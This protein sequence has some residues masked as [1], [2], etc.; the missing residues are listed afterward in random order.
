MSPMSPIPPAPRASVIIPHY[1][2]PAALRRCLDSVLAQRLDRGDFEII[3]VDNN[4]AEFPAGVAAAYPQVRFLREPR[5]GPGLARNAGVA[6]ATAP[7]LAFI[8]A[9]CRAEA[10]W[11][12]A[13]VDAIEPDP[14]RRIAG[15]DV[16]IDFVD[17][18]ALTALE[19][20]EAVFAYRQRFYIE[21]KHFSGTGNLAMGP[22][23]HAAVGPFAGI[24]IAEDRDWGT[25]AT[26]AGYTIRYVEAMRIYHP[27]RT[28]YAELQRKWQRHI[29]HDLHSHRAAGRPGW[30]WSLQ[31]LIVLASIGPHALRLLTSERLHGLGNRLRGIG[32]LARIRLWRVGEMRRAA[33]A[34]PVSGGAYWTAT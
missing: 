9:D 33:A 14:A 28:S 6:A 17:A 13:A 10:G 1:Q 21:K 24:E 15:G 30:R 23:V 3:V 11:L 25:R 29:A 5:P 8:D 32:M 16:R 31:G 27:A 4:S 12:Q 2:M 18:G 34:A 26:A 20:Y 22:A 19:A 7:V